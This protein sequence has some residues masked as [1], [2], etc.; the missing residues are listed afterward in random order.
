MANNNKFPKHIIMRLE[1]QIQTKAQLNPKK[2]DKTK[3]NNN[4][5]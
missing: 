1:K 5:K 4:I 3:C 2:C